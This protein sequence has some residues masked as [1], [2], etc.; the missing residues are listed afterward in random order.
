MCT[1]IHASMHTYHTHRDTRKK[2]PILPNYKHMDSRTRSNYTEEC[3][4]GTRGQ[5]VYLVRSTRI[6]VSLIFLLVSVSK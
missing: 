3:P 6:K 2:N 4:W 1:H 5:L